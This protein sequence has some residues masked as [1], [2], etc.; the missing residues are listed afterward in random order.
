MNHSLACSILL[1]CSA[2]VCGCAG[3]STSAPSSAGGTPS[4]STAGAAGAPVSSEVAGSG[5]TLEPG[6]A[7][8]GG[9][10]SASGTS[11]GDTSLA[12]A[13]SNDGDGE[14]GAPATIEGWNLVWSDEFNAAQGQPLDKSKWRFSV[15]PSNVNKELEYYSDRPENAG[16]DGAG[17]Y[18]IT[19]RKESYQG[20]SYTSAK[21]TTQ[22]TFQQKYGRFEARLK[23]PAGKG[24][25]PAFWALGANNVGWPQCGEMDIME[26][27]GSELTINRGSLHGPGYS[28][29]NPLTAVFKLSTGSDFSQDF[30]VF[31]TEWEENVVRFYVD[32][33]LYETRTPADAAGKQWVFDHSFYMILNVAVGGMLPGPPDDSV[34]PQALSID[35]VRVYSR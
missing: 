14:A 19:A 35:Y 4:S 1:A 6:G 34:F 17:H 7:T 24:L 26:T 29:G 2:S 8:N 30:H 28:G 22:A 11:G 23:L 20:R 21:F 31:A 12:D 32:G 27:I 13:G 33:T 25:W 16:F 18:L 9:S 5:G 15:G 10:S 3:S